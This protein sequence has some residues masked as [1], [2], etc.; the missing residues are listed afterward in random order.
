MPPRSPRRKQRSGKKARSKASKRSMKRNSPGKVNKASKTKQ[1]HRYRGRTI[2]ETYPGGDSD[3]DEGYL[4]FEEMDG[5]TVINSYKIA[6]I[7]KHGYW[8][9]FHPERVPFKWTSGED[10]SNQPYLYTTLDFGRPDKTVKTVPVKT[11][12]EKELTF[13]SFIYTEDFQTFV[14]KL[15]DILKDTN[16]RVIFKSKYGRG[17]IGAK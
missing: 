2:I 16:F 12:L 5:D 3:T 8:Q 13:R 6:W 15:Q 11:K 17:Y 14:T 7:E 1:K 10:F 9:M 4:M